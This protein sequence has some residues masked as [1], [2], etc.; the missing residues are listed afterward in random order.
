MAPA[1]KQSEFHG[2]GRGVDPMGGTCRD[3]GMH[4]GWESRGG[5]LPSWGR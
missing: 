5:L 3:E 1:L 2:G 4:R